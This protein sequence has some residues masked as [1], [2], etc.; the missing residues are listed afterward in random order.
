MIIKTQHLSRSFGAQCAVDRLNLEVPRGTIF[1]LLGPN[2]AGKTT[3]IRLLLGLVR[4]TSGR[5]EVCGYDISN[6]QHHIRQHTGILL[7]H[8]GL[9]ERLSALENLEW[10]GRVY[11]LPQATWHG[12]AKELLGLFGLWERRTER[13]EQWSK[14]MRQKLAVARA[15]LPYPELVFLDEPT[16]GLDPVAARE[17]RNTLLELVKANGTT[18]FLSTH[19]L[20]E[21]ERMCD[22]VGV[23]KDGQLVSCGP[24][25]ALTAQGHQQLSLYGQGFDAAM[26]GALEGLADIHILQASDTML[27]IIKPL[28]TSL[29][30]LINAIVLQGGSIDDIQA[31][32]SQLEG[33]FFALTGTDLIA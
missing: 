15:L 32:H 11:K 4:P 19:Q 27:T 29:A 12:R 33:A 26:P 6:Q 7:E 24:P 16:A 31:D 8:N 25:R 3:T 1:G 20:Q 5:A 14:G 2:G 10:I 30:Q 22:F 28:Q 17:L 9:Y 21:A 18:L 13:V 23:L